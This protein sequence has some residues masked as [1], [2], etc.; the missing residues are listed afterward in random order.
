MTQT[1]KALEGCEYP[2]FAHL[3]PSE[4]IREGRYEV[5]FARSLGELDSVLQLRFEVF[6]LELGEGLETSFETGRDIDAFDAICHHLIVAEQESGTV[7]GT[8][9]LQTSAMAIAHRGF[10]S[11]TEFDLSAFPEAAMRDAVELGRAC[12]ALDHRNTQVLFLLWRGLA[13]YVRANRK[14]YL[15]GCCSLTSQDATEARAVM[16][17]L[18]RRGYLHPSLK[19]EPVESC[20]SYPPETPADPDFK[21]K[22]PTLFRTYLRHGAKVCGPP[23]IDRQFKTID[24][25]VVFDIATMSARQVRAFFG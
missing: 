16:A 17:H 21:V 22:I 13:A 15:F 11:A 8:Y 18:E 12:V 23:A 9:R 2:V 10:Y 4:T 6:N 24:F 7:V 3:L 20:R 25:L 1:S 5:R 14:R 19:V